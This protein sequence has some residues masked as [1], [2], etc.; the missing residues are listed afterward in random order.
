MPI[1]IQLHFKEDIP[2]T[3]WFTYVYLHSHTSQPAATQRI[4]LNEYPAK[5][6]LL[7]HVSN[8]IFEQGFLVPKLRSAVH[9]EKSCG[10][11]VGENV[12]V[13]TL[14]LE[15][16]GTC[17]DKPLKLIISKTKRPPPPSL[18]SIINWIIL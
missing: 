11:R 14:L 2:T 17:E 1:V 10:S 12:C 16:Q 7:A 5:F 8:Y 18:Y 9:W 15:G 13:N 4:K 6:E 3:L